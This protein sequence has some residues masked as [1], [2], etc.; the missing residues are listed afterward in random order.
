MNFAQLST[1]RTGILDQ[2]SYLLTYAPHFPEGHQT[3]LQGAHD[4]MSSRMKEHRAQ[5]HSAAQLTWHYLAE[6]AL[7]S[8]IHAYLTGDGPAGRR[9]MQQAEAH[10]R[11]SFEAKK[12][13]T[14]FT[15]GFDGKITRATA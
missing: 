15:V 10:F 12:V 11:R 3:T 13:G 4:Q 1:L 14:E 9:R 5:L 7:A 2:M 6:Q 8:A